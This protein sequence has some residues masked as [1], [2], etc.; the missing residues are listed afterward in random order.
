MSTIKFAH[1]GGFS[2][3]ALRIDMVESILLGVVLAMIANLLF[4]GKL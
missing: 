4:V 2:N 1:S 3:K